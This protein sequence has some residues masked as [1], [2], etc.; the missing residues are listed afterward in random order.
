LV[1]CSWWEDHWGAD[2]G[3]NRDGLA[4]GAD[5]DRA[6]F[7]GAKDMGAKG[8]IAVEDQRM[9]MAKAIV[10]LQ[11]KHG[12]SWGNGAYKWRTTGGPVR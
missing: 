6:V 7:V 11:R 3:L 1:H 10:A 12:D 5:G 8:C 4:I 2:K 9:W